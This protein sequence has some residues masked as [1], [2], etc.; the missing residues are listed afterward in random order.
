MDMIS[1]IDHSILLWINSF[2]R[3]SYI[4]DKSVVL[5]T[6]MDFLK[7]GLFF[8]FLWWLWFRRSEHEMHDRIDV[9]RITAAIFL[10]IVIARALQMLLPGRPR[11]IHDPTLPFVLPFTA[12]DYLEH[13]S[14]FPSD[15][16]V[17]FFALATA[18]WARYRWFGAIAYCWI[19]AFALLPRI[20][21]GAHYPS[22]IIAGAV[23]GIA[24]MTILQA[25]P[26]PPAAMRAIYRIFSWER[27]YPAAFYSAAVIVTF[28]LMSLFN[29][30]RLIGR[31]IAKAFL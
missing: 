8:V 22:D 23:I 3:H 26:L 24:V 10:T 28:E 27:L 5:L 6:D 29:D 12:T 14:S 11:P 31:G 16:A 1:S 17:V 4:F 2:A 18:I 30:F 9:I 7:G 15:H 19:T 21:V 20:Y 13:W 25:I